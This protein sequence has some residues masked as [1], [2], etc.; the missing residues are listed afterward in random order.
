MIT[1]QEDIGIHNFAHD[2]RDMKH[3]LNL[4]GKFSARSPGLYICT[5]QVTSLASKHQVTPTFIDWGRNKICVLLRPTSWDSH[6]FKR[7]GIAFLA[8]VDKFNECPFASLVWNTFCITQQ[9]L[10]KGAT[11]G[12]HYFLVGCQLAFSWQY[13]VPKKLQPNYSRSKGL[14]CH[15]ILCHVMSCHKISYYIMLHHKRSLDLP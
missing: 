13:E 9:V 1:T 4:P 3:T 10:G 2:S 11:E 8:T 14:S 7:M 15:I 6:C 5:V 12:N